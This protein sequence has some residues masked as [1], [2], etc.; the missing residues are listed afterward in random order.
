MQRI[1]ILIMIITLLVG[2]TVQDKPILTPENNE[3]LVDIANIDKQIRNIEYLGEYMNQRISS[4]K[5]I[6]VKL[7]GDSITAGYGAPGYSVP[8]NNPIIFKDSDNTIY[9]EASYNTNSYANYFRHFILGLNSNNEFYNWGIGS[10]SAIWWN[11]RKQNLASE[12]IVFV[13]LGT[14]DR[15]AATSLDDFKIQLTSL[16]LHL[17]SVSNYVV[18]M[19]ANPISEVA[20]SPNNKFSQLE[21]NRAIKE[22]CLENDFP[23]ISHFDEFLSFSET[24]GG[25]T[26]LLADA[27]HPNESGYQLIWEK[28]QNSL[29]IYDMAYHETKGS[30]NN[31][32]TTENFNRFAR[33]YNQGNRVIDSNFQKN[34]LMDEWNDS[35]PKGATIRNVISEK[36]PAIFKGKYA[37]KLTSTNANAYIT[38]PLS[39]PTGNE[40]CKLIFAY[41]SVGVGRIHI[42]Q[43]GN[44]E[45]R[46]DDTLPQGKHIV[47]FAFDFDSEYLDKYSV[48]IYPNITQAEGGY[49]TVDS[50]VCVKDAYSQYGY[51][52]DN[53]NT[54][55]KWFGIEGNGIDESSAITDMMQKLGAS[56]NSPGYVLYFPRGTYVM[57]GITNLNKKLLI[58]GDGFETEFKG[59]I[60][61]AIYRNVRFGNVVRNQI[62][63]ES[64]DGKQYMLKVNNDGTLTTTPYGN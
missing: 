55:V 61:N 45:L 4:G 41:E 35:V 24:E 2:C 21:A 64:I 1:I 42:Q 46:I 28:I 49:V 27:I 11:Q 7:I 26:S 9:R 6:K 51:F 56:S 31:K 25:F 8:D 23:F 12:D 34:P 22:I 17:R 32:V 14:N 37:A 39:H 58:E 44:K 62:L 33:I 50:I 53:P 16:L 3:N 57:E 5:R 19:S 36:V 13:M 40:K 20:E 18:V 10:K 52:T 43:A 30:N 60:P 63:L 38:F 48:R 47:E 59:S 54:N 29:N 15:T